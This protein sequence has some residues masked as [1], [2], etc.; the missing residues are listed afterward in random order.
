MKTPQ[1]DDETPVAMDGVVATPPGLGEKRPRD[2]EFAD[3]EENPPTPTEMPEAEPVR[4]HPPRRELTLQDIM[5]TMNKGFARQ[6]I[7][8]TSMRREMG[9][10][11]RE[12]GEARGLAAKAV[13][14]ADETKESLTALEKRVAAIEAGSLPNPQPE[15]ARAPTSHKGA[16]PRDFDLLGGDDGDTLIIGGFRNWAD[17]EER[18]TEWDL[19]EP[20]LS[21]PLREAISEVI[22]PNSQCQIIIL[23][24]HQDPRGP[25]ETRKKM[26][27]WGKKFRDMALAHQASDETSQR[28]Y[29]AQPSK[30]FEMRQRNAKTMGMLDGLK[31]LL[32]AERAEKLKPDLS[33][34]RI[35]FERLLLAERAQG[36]DTPSP[37]M[38]AVNQILPDITR[39]KVYESMRTAMDQ[40]EKARKGP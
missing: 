39:E 29:Y 3:A 13:T 22:I 18:K 17:R 16:A 32:G 24:I 23:K 12:T 34:G 1:D 26:F 38:T 7:G 28:T 37:R 15:K 27:E 21:Q 11:Q 35:F 19:I 6:E 33:N 14:I 31:A 10:L 9:E 4:E 30:P 25:K 40:R 20:K 36:S 8:M 5:D 2:Q